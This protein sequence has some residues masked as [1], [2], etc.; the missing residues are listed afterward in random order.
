MDDK[1]C[2]VGFKTAIMEGSGHIYGY[3]FDKLE[4]CCDKFNWLFYDTGQYKLTH[5]NSRT[6]EREGLNLVTRGGMLILV[7]RIVGVIIIYEEQ[8][9]SCPFCGV[10]IEVKRTK[11]V[12][13]KPRTKQVP[14]G[15][16]EEI[17]WQE[18]GVG[19]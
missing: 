17:K 10:K 18:G 11:G 9:A 5:F 4:P 7:L 15:Y 19:Q 16:D 12:V 6:E 14:D 2:I 3:V 13:L 1:K 8:V